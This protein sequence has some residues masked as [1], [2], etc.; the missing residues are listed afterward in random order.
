M[1]KIAFILISILLIGCS[2]DNKPGDVITNEF[3]RIKIVLSKDSWEISSYTVNQ[4]N[5]TSIFNDFTFTFHEDNSV[6]VEKE[7][8]TLRGAWNYVSRPY[9]GELLL[10]EFD[11][12]PLSNL[13]HSW[14]IISVINS[15]IELIQKPNNATSEEKLTLIRL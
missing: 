13:S 9:D 10:L 11:T 1:R 2:T 5:R 6:S 8:D 7:G 4:E 14:K 12:P 3:E 15:K